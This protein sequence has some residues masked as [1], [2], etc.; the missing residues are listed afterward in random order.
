LAIDAHW[1]P[2]LNRAGGKDRQRLVKI[3]RER[4]VPAARDGSCGQTSADPLSVLGRVEPNPIVLSRR[5]PIA[6][7]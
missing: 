2:T 4:F 1:I 3:R 5:P 7:F 6:R